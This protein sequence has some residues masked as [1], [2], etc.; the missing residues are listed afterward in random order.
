MI[1]SKKL[2][3]EYGLTANKA[4]GQNFLVD[5]NAILSIVELSECSG[6]SVLEIGPGLG[7]LT[8]E[9]IRS[10]KNVVCIEIDSAMCELLKKTLDGAENLDIVNRDILKVKNDE[11]SSLLG[12]GFTVC[13]NLP[14]YITSDITMKLADSA[15]CISR[16]TL[17]MQQEAAEHF[18]ASPKQKCYTPVSV[19]SQRYYSICEKLR[20]SPSSYYPEPAVH[21]SVL[22]FKRNEKPYDPA[23][24]R[25]VKTAFSMR[26]KTL[27]NNLASLY[28]KSLVPAIIERAGLAPSCRAEE[29]TVSEFEA[30]LDAANAELLSR[31]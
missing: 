6:K 14:Y 17:M 11:L 19:I 25:L 13:A 28:D 4:L 21:S 26:R 18:L 27:R 1:D 8:G 15:L 12:E 31:N 3:K 9:L 2:I 5:E 29:L 22:V 24:S 10:A 20:L 23:F 30:L 7:A 16:M